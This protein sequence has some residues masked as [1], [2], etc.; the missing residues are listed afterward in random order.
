MD[1]PIGQSATRT[2]PAA[3]RQARTKYRFLI[4]SLLIV[5]AIGYMI[6]SA[7]QSGSEYYL[8]TGEIIAMGDSAV[9]QQVKMGGRVVEDSIQW[10]RSANT[11][12]FKLTDGTQTLPVLYGGVVPDTFDSGVDV[13]LEGKLGSTG[14]FQA[15]SMLAKCASKYEPKAS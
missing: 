4:A 5:A 2:R 11:V 15:S 7:T 8:T 6:F 12:A 9:G 3:R 13:I 14:E 10:D 1:V